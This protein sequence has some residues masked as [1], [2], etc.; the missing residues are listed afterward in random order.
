M[1]WKFCQILLFFPHIIFI[2]SLTVTITCTF[3]HREGP[4]FSSQVDH[5]LIV[6]LV[7][8]IVILIV[9]QY[10]LLTTIPVTALCT[11]LS[12]MPITSSSTASANQNTVNSI[13]HITCPTAVENPD[14]K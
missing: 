3:A 13:P 7:I 8:V 1:Q 12:G 11:E 14:T 9:M 6:I 10:L 5:T 4:R 2:G